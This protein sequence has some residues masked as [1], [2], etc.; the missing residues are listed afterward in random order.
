MAESFSPSC[1]SKVLLPR[2]VPGGFVQVGLQ[3]VISDSGRITGKQQTVNHA[4]P[5]LR[6]RKNS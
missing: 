3:E 1:F 4:V 5:V 6:Y 2:S